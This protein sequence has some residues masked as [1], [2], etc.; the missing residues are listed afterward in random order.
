MFEEEIHVRPHPLGGWEVKRERGARALSRHSS[1][2]E[3]T[4]RARYLAA[5]HGV[6]S[7]MTRPGESSVTSSLPLE[8]HRSVGHGGGGAR[9]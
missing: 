8:S 1:L 2:E 4:Q 3:A 5:R 6:S 9:V 7:C